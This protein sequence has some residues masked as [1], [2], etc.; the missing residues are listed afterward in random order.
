MSFNDGDLTRKETA[1]PMVKAIINATKVFCQPFS[2][3]EYSV[4]I[5]DRK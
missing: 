2:V 5:G 4:N 1:N 3:R